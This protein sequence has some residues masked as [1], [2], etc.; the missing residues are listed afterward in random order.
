MDQNNLFNKILYKI[1]QLVVVN[2]M[3]AISNCFA[4]TETANEPPS[5]VS[6]PP[7]TEPTINA[8][9]IVVL[10]CLPTAISLI[11]LFFFYL[12]H[13]N[14][15]QL[16]LAAAT[17]HGQRAS[18]KLATAFGLDPAVIAAFKS[19]TYSTVKDIKI[20]QQ[21]LAC[22]V[23]LNEFHDHEALRLLPE[24]SHV[25]HRDCIDEWLSLRVTC[26]VCRASLVPKP[27][28]LS[29]ETEL[30]CGP[31]R[32]KEDHVSVEV[33]DECYNDLAPPRKLSRSCSMG[34]PMVDRAIGNV[35]RYTLRL[36]ND[37]QSVLK[38]PSSKSRTDMSLL[39]ESSL[40]MSL[41]SASAKFVRGSDYF[42]YESF[43]QERR[44]GG[45]NFRMTS[46]FISC[47][48][49]GSSSG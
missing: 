21:V 14:E 45:R 18:M 42:E 32:P 29:C 15:R 37:V 6:P 9:M 7:K 20:G 31:N 12:R 49:S 19:F 16:A 46:S 28:Q 27:S 40:K 39:Q 17:G 11:C 30:S 23:C 1:K 22:A 38:N 24:C 3:L 36:S 33:I 25:F 8:P 26:P 10:A 2:L 4:A 43:G 47:G 35:D 44:C 5:A 41:R 13:Y 48:V 34:H